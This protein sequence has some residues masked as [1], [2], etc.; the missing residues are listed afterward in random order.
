MNSAWHT[1]EFT[2][3]SCCCSCH[4][5]AATYFQQENK[6]NINICTY[7]H[8]F[9]RV[10]EHPKWCK[11]L[12]VMC[13]LHCVWGPSITLQILMGLLVHNLEATL[14]WTRGLHLR[15][16]LHVS[17]FWLYSQVL[18]PRALYLHSPQESWGSGSTGS[19]EEVASGRR[20]K[21]RRSG[22]SSKPRLPREPRKEDYPLHTSDA[23]LSRFQN[24][25]KPRDYFSLLCSSIVHLSRVKTNHCNHESYTQ[26]IAILNNKADNWGT[27]MGLLI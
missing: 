13:W 25:K 23:H 2:K 11:I 14:S 19:W 24:K 9:M 6:L 7:V 4:Y 3:D 17:R 18:N 26:L 22:L 20:Q 1:G 21:G 8:V 12:L 16:F 15:C 5:L 27:S 10:H